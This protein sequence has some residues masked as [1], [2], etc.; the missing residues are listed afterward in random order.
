MVSN[1]FPYSFSLHHPYSYSSLSSLA[2]TYDPI[3][4]LILRCPL[5]RAL[6]LVTPLLC[7]MLIVPTVSLATIRAR[8]VLQAFGADFR[9]QGVPGAGHYVCGRSVVL[10]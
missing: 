9:R 8:E 6:L 2:S 1:T 10:R 5:A 7:D 4:N 3:D